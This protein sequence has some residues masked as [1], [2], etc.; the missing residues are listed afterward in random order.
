M[1]KRYAIIDDNVVT[2]L[3]VSDTLDGL[4]VV[5]PHSL[6]VEETGATGTAFIGSKYN[7]DL[8]KFEQPRV[9]DSWTWNEKTWE[10]IAPVP[11]PV[12]GKN[13]YWSEASASWNVI[14]PEAISEPEP[15]ATIGN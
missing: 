1:S 12:D 7:A 11:Y 10:W 6:H 4:V 5:F 9:Y 8:N 15:E 14:D 13:Y 2:N 3:V